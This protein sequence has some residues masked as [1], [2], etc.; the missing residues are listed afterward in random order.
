[1]NRGRPKAELVM[2]E[3]F[4]A[5][6]VLNGAVLATCKLHHRHQELLTVLRQIDAAVPAQFTNCQTFRW[7]ATADS[8]LEKQHRLFSR[9]SGT[10][11]VGLDG[12]F[13][14]V[15]DDLLRVV[16]SQ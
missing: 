10:G 4:A 9:I 3:L 7:T 1:M 5:L 16:L 15:E 13:E 8:I 6:N 12:R 14:R 2:T 11:Q